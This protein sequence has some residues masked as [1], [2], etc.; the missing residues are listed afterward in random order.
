MHLLFNLS[1][2]RMKFKRWI[3][4]MKI[5]FNCNTVLTLK[6]SGTNPSWKRRK[7]TTVFKSTHLKH[8]STPHEMWAHD[9]SKWNL[10][11]SAKQAPSVCGSRLPVWHFTPFPHQRWQCWT[12]FCAH[13]GLPSGSSVKHTFRFSPKCSLYWTWASAQNWP[14]DPGYIHQTGFSLRKFSATWH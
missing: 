1:E 2:I 11:C 6:V 13:R 8:G 10:P 14:L 7:N 9:F 5:T 12:Q 4:A 3:R